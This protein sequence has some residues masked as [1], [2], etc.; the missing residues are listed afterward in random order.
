MDTG[1]LF[2]EKLLEHYHHPRNV[3]TIKEPDFSS[4]EYNHSCGDQVQIE[5]RI[6]DGILTSIMFIG[7]GCIL[8][9][10]VASMLTEAC[11]GKTIK[12]VLALDHNFIHGLIGASLGPTRLRCALLPL[13]TLQHG[14]LA[15]L[16]EVEQ[17]DGQSE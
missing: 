6:Q 4:L 13:Y 10:A 7:S 3:G 14:V 1:Q 5:G 8:S 12:Q 9:Q 17:E 11:R 16:K 15:Y 2:R